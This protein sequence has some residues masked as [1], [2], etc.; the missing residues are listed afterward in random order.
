MTRL[1]T[2]FMCQQFGSSGAGGRIFKLVFWC[3]IVK[4]IT[5]KQHKQFMQ[6]LINIIFGVRNFVCIHGP[7]FVDFSFVC[8]FIFLF[9]PATDDTY[10]YIYKQ[11]QQP[12]LT[13]FVAVAVVVRFTSIFNHSNCFQLFIFFF[14]S[15][16]SYAMS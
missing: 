6:I 7:L 9:L 5:L 14:F 3:S 10:T 1:I 2:L 4:S 8:L 13:I 16:P 11:S 15:L 12:H